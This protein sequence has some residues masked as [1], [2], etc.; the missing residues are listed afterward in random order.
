LGDKLLKAQDTG[1]RHCQIQ[2]KKKKKKK[3]SCQGGLTEVLQP[4]ERTNAN[5]VA[6]S[7]AGGKKQA[8]VGDGFGGGQNLSSDQNP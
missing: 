8:S 2:R 6:L 4:Q 1:L 3:E 7:K 5:G